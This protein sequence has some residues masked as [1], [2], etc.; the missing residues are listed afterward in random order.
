MKSKNKDAQNYS[1]RNASNILA[2]AKSPIFLTL[3]STNKERAGET[4]IKITRDIVGE[5]AKETD[6]ISMKEKTTW[7]IININGILDPLNIH[8]LFFQ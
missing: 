7:I 1:Q 5:F 2:R 6:T 8:S 4:N 3:N